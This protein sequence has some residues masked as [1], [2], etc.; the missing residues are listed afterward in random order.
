M[1]CHDKP[2]DS[3]FSAKHRVVRRILF[4]SPAP[5]CSAEV[6]KRL[7]ILGNTRWSRSRFLLIA[8]DVECGRSWYRCILGRERYLDENALLK[9]R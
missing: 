6:E 8:L 4:E 1:I 5:V 9:V 2:K 3:V 7:G